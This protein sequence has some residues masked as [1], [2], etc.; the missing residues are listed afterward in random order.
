MELVLWT[1]SDSCMP[2]FPSTHWALLYLSMNRIDRKGQ[3]LSFIS[4]CTYWYKVWG[5]SMGSIEPMIYING[6]I[7][8]SDRTL[9]YCIMEKSIDTN[10]YLV[11]GLTW[12]W[13]LGLLS[14][15]VIIDIEGWV[16][17]T[18]AIILSLSNFGI[19]Y[20][21]EEYVLRGHWTSTTPIFSYLFL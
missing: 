20:K 5:V 21:F 8:V 14:W 12:L 1:S 16:I 10:F 18:L 2:Q 13:L 4:Y 11:S 19:I 3:T 7:D 17:L 6:I 9:Y 15:L